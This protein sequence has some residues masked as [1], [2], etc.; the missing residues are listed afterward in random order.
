MDISSYPLQISEQLIAMT[1]VLLPVM[2]WGSEVTGKKPQKKSH[3]K[4]SFW[5]R[6]K[7]LYTLWGPFKARFLYYVCFLST[8]GMPMFRENIVRF[9][10]VWLHPDRLCPSR[11]L[12]FTN[13]SQPPRGVDKVRIK[14]SSLPCMASNVRNHQPYTDPQFCR[15]VCLHHGYSP[16]LRNWDRRVAQ[17]V[18]GTLKVIQ[19]RILKL[20]CR[21]T[22][23]NSSGTR[24]KDKLQASFEIDL[25]NEGKTQVLL[26][27]VSLKIQSHLEGIRNLS[28]P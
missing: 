8:P 3:L 25:L 7:L 18:Q 6:F 11:P 26:F 20:T 27:L 16:D 28:L 24:H 2:E 10:H 1:I 23:S 14:S 5:K 9:P 22:L 17:L 12:R 13:A 19:L 15:S 4:G 21:G